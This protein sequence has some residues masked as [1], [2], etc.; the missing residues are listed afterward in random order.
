MYADLKRKNCPDCKES[1]KRDSFNKDR[2]QYDGLCSYCKKCKRTRSKKYRAD[3]SEHYKN[4]EFVRGLRRNYNMTLEDY[5]RIYKEQDG[6]CAICDKREEEFKRKLHVDH[7]HK[8][9]FIRGL[10]CTKCNPGLGYFEDS[11]EK[12]ELA[13]TYLNKF[14]K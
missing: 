11:I 10:L 1:L 9:G 14:K 13:I 7:D 8:T 6:K 12:L 5:E 2:T 4:Y 3:R